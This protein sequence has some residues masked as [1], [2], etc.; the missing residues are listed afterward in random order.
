[1]ITLR[2]TSLEQ[3][4]LLFSLGANFLTRVPGAIGLLWFLPLL[5]FGLGTD[6]YANLLTSMAL[7]SAAAFLSGG[8]SV[9]GRRLIGEAYSGGDRRGEA[10][11]FASLVVA[12]VAALSVALAIIAAYCWL[13][14]AGTI[15]LIV[16]TF[17]AFLVFLNTFDNVRLAYNEQYVTATLLII[18]QV[19][20][21]ALGFLLPAT[22]QSL[23]LG[24]LV[25]QSP[26]MLTSL[27]TFALLLRNRSYLLDGWPVSAWRVARQ[28]TMFA[29]ADGFM[30]ATLSLSVV[31]LQ[32]S[33]TAAVAAWF[34]TVVR[35]FQTLLVPVVLLLTPLSSYIRIRWN[36]KS[37][38]Q[39]QAFTT[40]TLWAGLCYG[41]IVALG[42]VV[43]SR[44]Y[45]DS[46]L[47]LPAPGNLLQIF[48]IFL[49]F[50]AIIAYKGYS[51]VAYLV[52]DESSHLSSWTTV[53]ISASVTLAA[54]ASCSVDPLSVI[55]VYALAAGLSMIVVL[56]W[57]VARFIR[58][59][60][61]LRA[62]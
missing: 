40:V 39:Q 26:Y 16:S 45:V 4:K 44:L 15:V 1:V 48:P 23:V 19:A 56:F 32:A 24:A 50:G 14:G 58:P 10:D 8:F 33:A 25:L 46:L 12:N 6:D 42:L 55:N 59:P 27:I 2:R 43:A 57:N 29:I 13:R 61:I 21:Y 51:S 37:I 38:A 11:G 35:L 5:R 17:P 30:L 36:G 20:G 49:L 3:R 53:A 47:H 9:V 60:G 7:G 28:G 52:L 31:W 22:R 18:L 54:V 62:G 41:A 34:A